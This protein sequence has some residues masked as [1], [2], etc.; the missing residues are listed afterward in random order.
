MTA[1]TRARRRSGSWVPPVVVFAAVL[2]LWEQ[3]FLYL[4]VKTFLIP[5]PSII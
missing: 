5:R 1:L 3:L 4:D 2:L